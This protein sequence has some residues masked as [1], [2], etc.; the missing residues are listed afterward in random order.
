MQRSSWASGSLLILAIGCT[1][2]VLTVGSGAAS[3]P[4]APASTTWTGYVENFQFLSG[5]DVVS[6]TLQNGSN[7]AV[8]GTVRFGPLPLLS[9]PTNPEVGYPPQTGNQA[10]DIEHFDFTILG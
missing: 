8:T 7:G 2:K 10:D 3:G 6:M 9:P 1:G 4:S 5:P